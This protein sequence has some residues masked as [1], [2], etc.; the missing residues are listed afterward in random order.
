[1]KTPR[2]VLGRL[3]E[4]WEQQIL[5]PVT[6]SLLTALILFAASLTFRP[7]RAFLFPPRVVTEYPLICTAEPYLDQAKKQVLVD[8]FI[9]NRTG[10]LYSREELSA[11]LHAHSQDQTAQPSPD[12]H[13][14]HARYVDGKPIGRI[15]NVLLDKEFNRGKG[16]LRIDRDGDFLSILV[17]SIEQRAIMKV[18]FVL[19]PFNVDPSVVLRTAKVIVPFD[20]R[21]YEDACYTR[22]E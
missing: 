16:A 19:E 4:N 5:R 11:L 15:E 3:C 2:E 10:N 6:T 13:L 17:D 18:T 21:Q 7:V 20:F 1:M 9:V 8:F 14:R 22:G 12:I